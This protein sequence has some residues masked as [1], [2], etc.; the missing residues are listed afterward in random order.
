VPWRAELIDPPEQI[1]DSALVL[2]KRP[3]LGITLNQK[4]AAKY[5]VSVALL[6]S[7]ALWGLPSCAF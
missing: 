5:A 1:S 7:M 6:V 4:T 3:G 2:S